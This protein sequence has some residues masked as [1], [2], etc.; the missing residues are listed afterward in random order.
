MEHFDRAGIA[1]YALSYDEADALRDFRDAHGITYTLLSDPNS[2]VIRAFGILNELI[3]PNDHPWFGIPYPGTYVVNADGV[4]TH[5]FFDNNLAVRAGPEQL[6]QAAL[7]R[8][9]VD[10]PASTPVASANPDAVGV[11]IALDGAELATTVQKDLVVRF[12]VPAGRHVYAAPAPAGSVA[13]DV[14]LDDNATLVPRA[15]VR[16]EGVPH[17]LA[18]TGEQFLV[19]DGTFELRLPLTVNNSAGP[20]TSEVAVAGEIRWQACDDEVC[21]IPTSQRFEMTLP[22]AA[23]PPPALGGGSGAEREPNAMRHFQR[24]AERRR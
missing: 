11:S 20:K 22:V 5:K 19:H 18:G 7:G 1:V 21:D 9:M 12:E 10:A 14:V 17:T 6:Y 8:P 15:L 4:I 2:E 24:M 13:V 3:D 16:P 23:S